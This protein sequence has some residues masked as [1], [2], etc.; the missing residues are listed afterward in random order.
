MLLP[1]S[2]GLLK[3][4]APSHPKRPTACPLRRPVP[5]ALRLHSRASVAG[6]AWL[7]EPLLAPENSSSCSGNAI[8]GIAQGEAAITVL[9]SQMP[10][11][12]ATPRAGTHSLTASPS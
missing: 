7:Q 11:L 6:V 2:L 10:F 12:P 8:G 9:C 1:E 4:E 3:M 5:L